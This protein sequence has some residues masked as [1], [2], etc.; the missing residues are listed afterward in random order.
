MQTTATPAAAR[1]RPRGQIDRQ[2]PAA[3]RDEILGSGDPEAAHRVGMSD[4]GVVR[5]VTRPERAAQEEE[6]YLESLHAEAVA[7]LERALAMAK[8]RKLH[9][10]TISLVFA[11]GCYGRLIPEVLHGVDR[12]IGATQSTVH[13]LCLRTFER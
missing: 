11:D 4:D 1:A 12:L 8:E 3:C 6:A 10:V 9:G 5:L 2:G 7:M 13:D